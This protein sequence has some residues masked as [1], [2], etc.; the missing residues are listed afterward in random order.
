VFVNLGRAH[1]V[2]QLDWQVG[3]GA[4]FDL[5]LRL[6]RT[7]S[8]GLGAVAGIRG[9]FLPLWHSW[10]VRSEMHRRQERHPSAKIGQN[11]D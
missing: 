2:A 1:L 9:T 5:L 4:I 11:G 3:Q 8:L 7:S 10:C 6:G